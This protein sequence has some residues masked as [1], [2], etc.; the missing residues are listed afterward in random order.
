MAAAA[1]ADGS[2]FCARESSR[3]E[4]ELGFDRMFAECDQGRPLQ[5]EGKR[6]NRVPM[7]LRVQDSEG[8]KTQ[9][10]SR[11]G[12]AASALHHSRDSEQ[13]DAGHYPVAD[14]DP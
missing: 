14:R 9:S 6:K 2:S 12:G 1:S 7:I 11:K 10:Q 4:V 13:P 3:P 5:P 8:E